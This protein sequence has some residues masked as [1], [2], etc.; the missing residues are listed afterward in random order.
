[1]QKEIGD[2][3][4]N[5]LRQCKM[6]QEKK[7]KDYVIATGKTYSIK[8]FI[9]IATKYLKMKVKWTGKGLRKTNKYE[10]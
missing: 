4:K 9:N 10:N 7:P 6:M 3:Q 8:E 2:M 5:T 1:M